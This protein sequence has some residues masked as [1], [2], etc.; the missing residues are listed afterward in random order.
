VDDKPPQ[1]GHEKA[2]KLAASL[3]ET[4]QLAIDVL[5]VSFHERFDKKLEE[6]SGTKGRRCHGI[7]KEDDQ[8]DLQLVVEGEP[9]GEKKVRKRFKGREEGQHGPVLKPLRVMS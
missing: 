7:D 2:N 3:P 6:K 9:E 5:L 1:R 4:Q 8:K